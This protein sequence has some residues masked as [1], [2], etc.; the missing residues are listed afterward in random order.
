[1]PEKE[2]NT[3]NQYDYPFLAKPVP[4][5]EQIWAEDVPPRVSIRCKTYMHES[6]IRDAIEGF[7]MQKTTFRVEVLIHDDASTDKTADII[8]EYEEKYPKLIKVT[9]QVENQYKKQPK[10]DKY[11]K[12]HPISG[13]YVAVCEGDDYW[14]DPLKL[15]KQVLFL[16]ANPAYVLSFHDCIIINEAG[17]RIKKSKLRRRQRRDYS[18]EDLAS[19]CLVPTLS[20]CYRAR[21]RNRIPP[22]PPSVLNGDTYLFSNLGKFGKGHY[23]KDI[24]PA[25]YRSHKGGIWSQISKKEKIKNLVETY[26]V[27]K[28]VHYPNHQAVLNNRLLVFE[29][30]KIG[31]YDNFKSRLKRYFFVL[32]NVKPNKFFIKNILRLHY[33][34]LFSW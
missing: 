29:M 4:V 7:I 1:M 15:Y 17:R 14:T 13:K 23:H 27:L 34:L 2:I 5:T 28:R 26:S 24:T 6:F 10:T 19:G 9:Y 18:E 32:R 22:K 12:P 21:E 16:D 3:F 8:R 30:I 25:V 33:Y 11:V 20:V 31:M